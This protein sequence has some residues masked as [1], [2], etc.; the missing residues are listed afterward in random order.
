MATIDEYNRLLA[1]LEQEVVTLGDIASKNQRAEKRIKEGARDELDFA[2]LG[3]TIHNLYNGIENY[4]LRIAKFFE[5]QLPENGWH[6]EL[7]F[8][9]TLHIEDLRPAL[10]SKETSLLVQE[11]RSF[12]HAFRNIYQSELDSEKVMLLQKKIPAIL[13]HF[14]S[15]HDEFTEKLRQVRDRLE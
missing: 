7:I 11:L 15:S 10:F 9:M 13:E 2:A 4:C 1:E 14:Y 5:N 6:R 8:R 12:R 3:Y